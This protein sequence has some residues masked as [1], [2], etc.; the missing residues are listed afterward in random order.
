MPELPEVQTT[1]AGLD[2]ELPY[3]FIKDVWTDLKSKDKRNKDSVKNP[4]YFEYFKKEVKGKRILGATR[5]GKNILIRLEGRKTILIHMKM[6]GHLL[7]GKYS[8]D[9]KENIWIPD[10]NQKNE[11]LNDPFNRFIRV[12][13]MLK[14][15][16]RAGN[17]GEMHL[18]FSDVR[19][20]GKITLVDTSTL[21][22]SIHLAYLGPEPL[23]K[24]FSTK[25]MAERLM[26]KPNG[27]IKTVLMDQS[28]IAGIGNIYSDEILWK[29]GIH[30]EE[31]VKNI[32]AGELGAI[33]K[34][35]KETLAQG[36]DFGGD[37]MSDY[38]NIY[39]E[40]GSFQHK[41]NAYK[42]SG[43]PCNKKGCDG[44]IVRK[45]IG[46]RSAHFCPKHQK[47]KKKK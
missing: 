31:I 11:A 19:K 38:R 12:V 6:T 5:R 10:K 45:S 9:K 37:S 39:G 34:A 3:L 17:A 33:Y 21:S 29:A 13:F 15:P 40:K 25:D 4:K 35:M 20:F 30:P 32:S 44:T 8:Y 43:K 16:K 36:I 1:T 2:K 26:K 14:D 7:F 18:A 42:R 22:E 27:K 23:A 47:L 41:H 46:G 24:D 28:V